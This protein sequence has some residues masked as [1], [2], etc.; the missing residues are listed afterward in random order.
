MCQYPPHITCTQND[1]IDDDDDDDDDD[2][3]DDKMLSPFSTTLIE[4]NMTKNI[5]HSGPDSHHG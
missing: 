3:D 2:N 5:F 4:K 1:E